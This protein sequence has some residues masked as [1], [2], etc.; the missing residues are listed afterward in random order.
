MRLE[1]YPYSP[2]EAKFQKE[3]VTAKPMERKMPSPTDE[4][5]SSKEELTQR[6][7]EMLKAQMVAMSEKNQVAEMLEQKH[8]LVMPRV[9]SIMKT[10]EAT[11][12]KLKTATMENKTLMAENLRLHQVNAQQQRELAAL[13]VRI[14]KN[15]AEEEGEER[16]LERERQKVNEL[17]EECRRKDRVIAQMKGLF[18]K[19]K[20]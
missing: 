10:L 19:T 11:H 1:D 14:A 18:S 9:E 7:E 13:K 8:K 15:E 5:D 16:L 4:P 6:L 17:E 12:A 3:L 2:Q 20:K